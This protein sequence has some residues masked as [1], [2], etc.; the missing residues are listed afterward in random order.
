MKTEEL[1][2]MREHAQRQGM[3]LSQWV[4]ETLRQAMRLQPAHDVDRKLE[5]VR[6]AVGHQFPTAD[7]DQMLSEIEE[8]YRSN[9]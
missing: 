5:Y 9:S 2:R 6:S 3:N 8:G 4:R 1:E 7:I